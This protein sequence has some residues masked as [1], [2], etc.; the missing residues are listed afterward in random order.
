[1]TGF[2]FLPRPIDAVTN[3]ALPVKAIRLVAGLSVVC[4]VMAFGPKAACGAEKADSAALRAI[5][6]ALKRVPHVRAGRGSAKV[7]F[8]ENGK[9]TSRLVDFVFKDASS[10]TDMYELSD[11]GKGALYAA[12]ARN[13]K[14]GFTWNGNYVTVSRQ[15]SSQFDNIPGWDYNP[16]VFDLA[17]GV[18]KTIWEVLEI[19]QRSQ[20]DTTTVNMSPDGILR[21]TIAARDDR[22]GAES[23]VIIDIDTNAGYRLA[24][25]E[26]VSKNLNGPGSAN[27]QRMSIQWQKQDDQWYPRRVL[28]EEQ[29]TS[30]ISHGKATEPRNYSYRCDTLIESIDAKADVDDKEFTVTGLGLPVGTMVID[31][32]LGTTYRIGGEI[33]T[34][35]DLALAIDSSVNLIAKAASITQQATSRTGDNKEPASGP[36]RPSAAGDKDRPRHAGSEQLGSSSGIRVARMAV[37]GAGLGLAGVAAAYLLLSIRRW[38]ARRG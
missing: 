34:E 18:Q 25:Y 19:P 10:R 23:H 7:T 3:G 29:G 22:S 13:P 24:L 38:L 9:T 16:N 1:M 2:S 6:E 4:G 8:E 33:I 27:T 5:G 31:D 37:V 12:W 21:V 35:S 36:S 26:D 32:I 28:Y 20:G 11:T 17:P 30:V 14:G 15:P